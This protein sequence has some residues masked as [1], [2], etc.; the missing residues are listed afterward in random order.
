M[1]SIKQALSRSPSSFLGLSGLVL[2]LALATGMGG[3]LPVQAQNQAPSASDDRFSAS[4]GEALSVEAP[5]VLEND[6]D[7]DGD[8]LAASV[9]S[10]PSNGSITLDSDGSFEYTPDTGS[11]GPDTV[12]YEVTDGNGGSAMARVIITV[13]EVAIPA[14]RISTDEGDSQDLFLGLDPQATD[15]I[16]AALGEEEQPPTPPSEL[17]D[18]RLISE[19]ISAGPFGEG[20]IVDIRDG[21]SGFA[22]TKMHE[23]QYQPGSGTDS[24]TV[25]WTLPSNVTGTLEDVVTD[26]GQ[27]RVS[28][29]GSGSY[30][31][32]NTNI[33]KLYVTLEYTQ[34]TPP[35]AEA[36]T[37]S[38]TEGETLSIEAPGVL[39]NDSDPDGDV[40][41]ASLVSDVS[42]GNLT[43][44]SDGSFEYTPDTGFTGTEQFTYDA[45]DGS[46]TDTASVTLEVSSSGP[47]TM[48]G[49]INESEYVPL[50]GNSRDAEAGFGDVN[51]I[52]SL[53]YFP[54]EANQMLY[55][56]AAGILEASNTNGYGFFLNVSGSGA[57]T[58]TPTGE[59]LGLNR[60]T[61][62]HFLSGQEGGTNDDFTADFEVDYATAVAPINSS[63]AAAHLADYT[64]SSPTVAALD[65]T[66]QSGTPVGGGG[67]E[68]ALLNSEDPL[69]GVEWKIPFNALG[70]TADQNLQVSA[71]IV[72]NTGYF[73]NEIIP[74]DG[75]AIAGGVTDDAGNPGFNAQWNE[76]TGGS[77]H[78]NGD[79][80]PVEMVSFAAKHN[81]GGAVLHW[82]TAS[83]TENAG[84]AVQHA[85]PGEGSEQ[86]SWVDGVGTT[87]EAQSY[88]FVTEDLSAGTHRFRLKQKDLDGSISR[89]EVVTIGIR[90]EGPI[91]VRN[92]APN[93]VMGTSV[94]RFTAGKNNF[95][96]VALYDV[97]GRKV[98][99]LYRG[100]V[101]G[102][103]SRRV[104]LDASGLSSGTY[105][106]RLTGDGFTKN[107]RITVAR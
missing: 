72:S 70:A 26:G 45:S 25:A 66:D 54:D 44:D 69:T 75:T 52:D 11:A 12:N 63:E 65:T 94:L 36:D 19:D 74:G 5:G 34:N 62:Y 82:T 67:V 56:A 53:V 73:S 83:E 97:L 84:F 57:P 78:T 106:L 81:E 105:F 61:D 79:G 16:D 68:Y 100:R 51:D 23:I 99:T 30:T 102:G 48:D 38:T 4:T 39:N 103:Q 107:H 88:R 50:G 17:F 6:T 59:T 7:P 2:A 101:S 15:G 21:S 29:E 14:I 89:S 13:V 76:Y 9:V 77:W 10:T 60:S 33:T 3:A 22:G 93:P 42:N 90:P 8:N 24:V 43:L 80:L 46:N 96:T 104:T 71:F 49:Q 20:L 32:T 91:A 95:L 64:G 85:V 47:I 31:I 92:V 28:M 58:G 40:L 55:I 18:A 1:N 87:T 86:I 41:T 27:F 35:T 98:R 37:Y